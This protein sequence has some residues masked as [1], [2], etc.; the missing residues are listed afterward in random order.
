ME[1][2]RSFKWEDDLTNPP[3]NNKN[4]N[5][6]WIGQVELHVKEK[7]KPSVFK[8][9]APLTAGIGVAALLFG[10][11]GTN[12]VSH[13]NVSPLKQNIGIPSNEGNQNIITT[14][15]VKK[16]LEG[17]GVELVQ[18]SNEGAT[19]LNGVMPT[20][21][22]IGAPAGILPP[23]VVQIYIFTDEKEREIG[24][25]ESQD[26][27]DRAMQSESRPT[28]WQKSN[29]LVF[30]WHHTVPE[31][32]KVIEDTIN[33][34]LKGWGIAFP[35]TETTD[36]TNPDYKFVSV[37][38]LVLTKDG[39]NTN[40]SAQIKIQHPPSD[41]HNY[42]AGLEFFNDEG[43]L[44][45]RNVAIRLDFGEGVHSFETTR[46]GDFTNY[47]TVRLVVNKF[48]SKQPEDVIP[49]NLDIT[50]TKPTTFYKYPDDQSKIGDL[51]LQTVH[52]FAT[53]QK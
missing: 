9:F 47:K 48:E 24:F 35:N 13:L 25:E 51:S 50:L 4:T 33:K 43:E 20:E 44:I 12:F 11:F 16:L 14:N 8:R 49:M 10:V 52:V 17:Q 22:A 3:L 31:K 21:F 15:H 5:K 39:A 23:G 42:A 28:I 27:M 41:I 1:N 2:K 18:S 34:A 38:D 45:W 29:G 19:E 37:S 32:K 46:P 26:K 6:E 36:I 30:I 7:R 53:W 40:F